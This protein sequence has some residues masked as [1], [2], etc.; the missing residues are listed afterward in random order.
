MWIIFKVLLSLLQYFFCCMV[1]CFLY[2]GGMWNFSSLTSDG[3]CTPALEGGLNYGTQGSPKDE[4]LYGRT[5]L[6]YRSQ[7]SINHS[8][9]S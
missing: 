7:L 1:G 9:S 5:S 4:I 3:T 6:S 8:F 2:L